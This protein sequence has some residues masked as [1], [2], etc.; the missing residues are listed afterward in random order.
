MLLSR[1]IKMQKL[2][3]SKI[4]FFSNRSLISMKQPFFQPNSQSHFLKSNTLLQSSMNPLKKFQYF[5][6]QFV[7]SKF[8][9]RRS[10]TW[11]QYNKHYGRSN[12]NRLKGPALFTAAFC[13]GTTLSMPYLM[14]YTP[15][16]VFKRSPQLLVYSIIAINGGVFLMWKSVNFLKFLTRYGLL[17]KDNVYSN[18]S[19][20]GSA[21]SHQSFMH[22][23]VN[24]F[25]LQSFGTSLCMMLGPT[26]FLTMYLNSAVISSF[27]SIVIPTLTRTSLAV[28]SLGASGA[29]FSVVGAFSY[30]IPKAPI[31]LFF[32]PIPGG[33]W[34]AFLGT[35]AYN[36]AGL[37]FR[38]GAHDYAAHLGG[39]F[40]GVMYGW[41][42][43]KKMRERRARVRSYGF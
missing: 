24:M 16:A 20:L 33:A 39:S 12:W 26:G 19:L 8:S 18:W 40:A 11:K 36:V 43:S 34:F 3:V 23:L 13:I 21:F 15:L 29:I 32:I 30:L 10:D 6:A 41:Y 17:V 7:T 4:S 2:P 5:R 1:G 28:G 22:L 25:V 38:W 14:S 42:Y 31:A 27:L 35:V 37:M 9:H